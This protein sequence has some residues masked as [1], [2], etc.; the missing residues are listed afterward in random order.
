ME[1]AELLQLIITRLSHDLDV[2]SGAARTAHEAA[3]H[4]ENIPDNK[5]DTLALEASYIAQAQANRASE[6]RQAIE[7]FKHL[8][9]HQANG[10]V[11]RLAALVNLEAEDGST[12][13]VFVG[14]REGGLKVS[15][16]YGEVVVI[17]PAS[18][19]G[20]VLIGKSVGDMVETGEGGGRMEYE[21]VAVF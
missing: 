4:A 5:Y 11:V 9:L 21:I 15:S 6:I 7:A 17:T 13:M 3:T 18:P 16:P 10:Q 1:K 20:S 2:L 12:R 8:R 19:L 14:P